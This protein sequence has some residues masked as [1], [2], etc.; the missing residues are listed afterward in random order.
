MSRP[1]DALFTAVGAIIAA[2]LIVIAKDPGL[3]ERAIFI[4]GGIFVTFIILG[5]MAGADLG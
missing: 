3:T 5:A 4:G 1:R 2:A